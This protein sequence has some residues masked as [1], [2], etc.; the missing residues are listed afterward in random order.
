MNEFAIEADQLGKSF[1]AKRVL[2]GLDLEVPAGAIFGL[3]GPNG[4]GKTT[5]VRILTTL[6]LPDTGRALVLGHDVVRQPQQVRR[7][8]GLT[9]QYAAVDNQISAAENLY[10][11]GRLFGMRP[12]ASRARAAELLAAFGLADVAGSRLK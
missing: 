4:A 7:I 12:R 11:V 3:L 9:G 5:A 8:I 1:G 10:L 6:L 2:H